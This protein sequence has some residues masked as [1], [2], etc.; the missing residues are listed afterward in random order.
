MNPSEI[1]YS[2]KSVGKLE[3]ICVGQTAALTRPKRP[4]EFLAIG[5]QLTNTQCTRFKFFSNGKRVKL[6][7]PLSSLEG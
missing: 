7:N 1:K 5:A 4:M 3:R 6:I 2:K